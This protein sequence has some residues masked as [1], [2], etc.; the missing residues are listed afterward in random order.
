MALKWHNKPGVILFAFLLI[1]AVS[2]AFLRPPLLIAIIRTK[3]KT[4]PGT[5]LHKPNV[6]HDKL[7]TL[8]NGRASRNCRSTS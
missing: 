3:M 8:R 2:G 7:R 4:I 5:K 1:L 6:W